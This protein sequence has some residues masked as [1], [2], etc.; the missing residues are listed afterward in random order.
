MYS[1]NEA[2][3]D[4]LYTNSYTAVRYEN[5]VVD[6]DHISVVIVLV[7]FL[8]YYCLLYHCELRIWQGIKTIY[9]RNNNILLYIDSYSAVNY[10]NLVVD[11]DDPL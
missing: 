2:N 4:L 9:P 6:Q 5:L 11:R 7:F 1:R 10:E 8:S 3:K